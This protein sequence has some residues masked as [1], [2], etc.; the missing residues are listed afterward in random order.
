MSNGLHT[1]FDADHVA[2]EFGD[3]IDVPESISELMDS[4]CHVV[5]ETLE[6]EAQFE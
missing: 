5:A 6:W 3:F 2:L 1:L 4:P